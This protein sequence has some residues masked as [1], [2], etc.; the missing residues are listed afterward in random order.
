KV[1]RVREQPSAVPVAAG[2]SKLRRRPSGSDGSHYRRQLCFRRSWHP[3]LHERRQHDPAIE[4]GAV[5]Q[6]HEVGDDR[7]GGLLRRGGRPDQPVLRPHPR[8]RQRPVRI[9]ERGAGAEQ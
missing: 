7:R 8:R 2:S 1:H 3:R 5:L 9:R 4:A 6:R